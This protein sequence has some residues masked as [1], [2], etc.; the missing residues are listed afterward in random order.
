M[1]TY[2]Q[3]WWL[4]VALSAIFVMFGCGPTPERNVY[5]DEMRYPQDFVVS[6]AFLTLEWRDK[7]KVMASGFLI[8]REHGIFMTAKHFT[9]AI[10]SYGPDHC[11]LF[12]NGRVYNAVLLRVPPVRDAALLKITSPFNPADFPEPM[13]LAGEEPKIG[14]KIFFR[15]FHPHVYDVRQYNATRGQIDKVVDI[16]ST[17]YSVRML[18][19][20]KESQ[21]VFDNLEAHRVKPGDLMV[22]DP[23]ALHYEND[24]YIKVRSVRDHLFSFGGLSGGAAINEKGQVVGVNTAQDI[25]R[26]EF[27]GDWFKVDP[28]GTEA[29]MVK[30]QMYDTLYITPIQSVAELINYARNYRY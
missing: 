20:S 16:F 17:F 27:E 28:S 22:E 12:F 13:P 19:T 4:T 30:R 23:D 21:V 15:G 3:V 8:S 2:R 10:G 24:R 29:R 7:P 6:E 5:R 1:L 11:K 9:D 25:Y 14:E 26:F 18:D